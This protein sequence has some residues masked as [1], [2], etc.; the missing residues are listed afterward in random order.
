MSGS[1]RYVLD[2]NVFIS[3]KNTYY[4]FDLCPGF[5]KALIVQHEAK[6]VFSIDR[7][8][9]ELIAEGDELSKWA[10]VTAPETFFKKTQDA[11]VIKAFQKMVTWTNA[12]PQFTSAAKS[13]FADVADGWLMGY[14]QVNGSTVVTHEEF[15]PEV[16]RKVP[17]P[18]LC[19]EFDIPYVNT[20]EMLND[21][22]VRF[23][24]STKTPRRK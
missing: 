4:A 10:K 17:I 22:N 12:Q 2:A 23:V 18:N 20:F 1:K 21:L 3:A 8:F 5:W 11:A 19:L 7:V 6:R 13:D 16:K 9:G 14:A 15:T 24:L